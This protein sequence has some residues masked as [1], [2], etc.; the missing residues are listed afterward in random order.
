MF[1]AIIIILFTADVDYVLSVEMMSFETLYEPSGVIQIKKG[2]VIIVEDEGKRSL[3][4]ATPQQSSKGGILGTGKSFAVGVSV[5]DL[6][7][8]TAT[9]DSTI[10]AITSHSLS[11][12][13]KR[14]EEREQLLKLKVNQ[15]SVRVISKYSS[16]R[17]HLVQ[18]LMALSGL[19][20]N[21]A[22]AINIEGL[23]FDKSGKKLLIGLRS[24]TFNGKAIILEILNPFTMLE[25]NEPPKFSDQLI[26]LDIGGNGIRAMEYFPHLNR[27]LLAS[28]SENKKGKLR[29]GIWAWSGTKNTL[30]TKVILPKVKGIKNFEGLSPLVHERKHFLLIVC[31]DDQPI[32]SVPA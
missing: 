13:G 10:Y 21:L 8:V 25:N 19:D 23:S 16:L 14:K 2:E 31:D 7:G 22:K 12:K 4:I 27:Y 3:Y 30:P 26:L 18:R 28:E 9:G 29:S 15:N 1:L 32:I 20:K 24:P 6:E 11:K 17:P 5:D